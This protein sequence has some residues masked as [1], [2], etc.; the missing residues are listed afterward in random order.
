MMY[1]QQEP[2]P[3]GAYP[4]PQSSQAP[5]LLELPE[6]FLEPFLTYSGYVTLTT[7]EEKVVA[8]TPNLEAWEAWKASLP[9]EPTA[10]AY[11][12]LELT[13]QAITDL[14]LS[15]I[16]QGQAITD[17]EIMILEGQAHV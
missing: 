17:L 14:E 8:L 7:L 13:Q 5:G 15:D 4:P 10:P 9:E 2:N 11:T 16:E 6:E 3:S 1:L 12:E